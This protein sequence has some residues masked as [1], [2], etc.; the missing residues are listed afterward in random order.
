MG[1]P[2]TLCANP[3]AYRAH[4]AQAL[5]CG[6][7]SDSPGGNMVVYALPCQTRFSPEPGPGI[8]HPLELPCLPAPSDPSPLANLLS[9]GTGK[10]VSQLI[11]KWFDD[12]SHALLCTYQ[13]GKERA[14][15]VKAWSAW[16]ED[17]VCRGQMMA[18]GS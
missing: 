14:V 16:E 3:Q 5:A 10:V 1:C 4:S 7:C 18:R 9:Q 8:R 6:L 12:A 17:L 13:L 15:R 11:S 2:S